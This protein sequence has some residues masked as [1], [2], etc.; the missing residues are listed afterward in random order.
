[1][2]P[3]IAVT[4]MFLTFACATESRNDDL[5][6][7]T[8]DELRK[9]K[10][11]EIVGDL[12]CG[13]TK[14]LL[15]RTGESPLKAFRVRAPKGSKVRITVE[16]N[17][18]S[19]PTLSPSLYLV[20]SQ[21]T[22]FGKAKKRESNIDA[23]VLDY[24]M[25]STA[26][27]YAAVERTTT[28][29]EAI[30]WAPVTLDCTPLGIPSVPPA[31]DWFDESKDCDGPMI[32][33]AQAEAFLGTNAF[34]RSSSVQRVAVRSRTCSLAGSCEPWSRVD[35]FV[36]NIAFIGATQ[37]GEWP[38]GASGT[39]RF[40]ANL[41]F[42]KTS[43]GV[44]AVIE[45]ASVRHYTSSQN[46]K[47]L[48]FN[49]DGRSLSSRSGSANIELAYD[50]DDYHGP[51]VYATDLGALVDASIKVT[52]TC[53]ILRSRQERRFLSGAET[54]IRQRQFAVRFHYNLR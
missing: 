14:E 54:G 25:T 30:Y 9:V 49:L 43:G 22:E 13:E 7:A 46:A 38:W 11:A 5:D 15:F 41:A 24:E 8:D 42:E 40:D 48:L 47:G 39:R 2:K 35:D 28:P 17:D 29:R 16:H 21:G 32:T 52:P 1:M 12:Q 3:R 26:I 6:A 51:V 44:R 23:S 27:R 19:Q 31:E 33:N 10:Q 45:D 36:D 34:R 20:N 37:Y 53:A 4:L 50:P 18:P